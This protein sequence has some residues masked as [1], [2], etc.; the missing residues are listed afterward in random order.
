MRDKYL[1]KVLEVVQ[2]LGSCTVEDVIAAIEMP[3]RSASTYLSILAAKGKIKRTGTRRYR[4]ESE[5]PGP[6][7]RKY[8][9]GRPC[10]EYRIVKHTK[11]TSLD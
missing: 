8:R 10:T 7:T 11:N 9:T 3:K 1:Q 4:N 2:E 6:R 5:N